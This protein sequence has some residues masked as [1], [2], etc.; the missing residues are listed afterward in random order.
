ML[1]TLHGFLLKAHQQRLVLYF[2]IN[3]NNVPTTHMSHSLTDLKKSEFNLRNERDNNKEA[4]V[5]NRCF[6]RP[7]SVSECKRTEN[8]GALTVCHSNHKQE[9]NKETGR[10]KTALQSLTPRL[11]VREVETTNCKVPEMTHSVNWAFILENDC[12][13]MR[14]KVTDIFPSTDLPTR[15]QRTRPHSKQRFYMT[16]H[17]SAYMNPPRTQKHILQPTHVT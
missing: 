4:Q 12:L 11:G 13:C 10:E 6:Q 1:T 3:G 17:L 16:H 8:E 15:C 7:F 5:S 9:E 14:S 2:F